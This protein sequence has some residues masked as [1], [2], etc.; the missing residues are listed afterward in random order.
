[1]KQRS[2]RRYTSKEI[3]G[4]HE[5]TASELKLARAL[6]KAGVCFER[7]VPINRFI[8]DFLVD[9]WLVVE[10]DGWSHL[11][12]SRQLE[13]TKR[14]SELESWGFSVIRIPAMEISHR[15]GLKQWVNK[16]VKLSKQGPPGLNQTGFENIHLKQAVERVRRE[17]VEQARKTGQKVQEQKR[18]ASRVWADGRTVGSRNRTHTEESMH[19]YFGPE[20]EDFGKLLEQYDWSKA[21]VKHEDEPEERQNARGRRTHRRRHK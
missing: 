2:G 9:G 8:V 16:I 17:L 7:E 4:Y 20:A 14:Q 6:K 12:A 5:D 21:P 1:V 3:W 19:D 15:A 11:T 13:D 18:E 10:V